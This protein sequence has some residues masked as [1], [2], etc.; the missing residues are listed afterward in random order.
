MVRNQGGY[1]D[2]STL[3]TLRGDFGLPRFQCQQKDCQAFH[4]SSFF[5]KSLVK[6][7]LGGMKPVRFKQLSDRSPFSKQFSALSDYQCSV[8]KNTIFYSSTSVLE[9]SC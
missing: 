4:L 6:T 3:I 8:A 2:T 7:F 1:R 9:K 5:K